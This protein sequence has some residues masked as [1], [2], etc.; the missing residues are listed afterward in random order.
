MAILDWRCAA[1]GATGAAVRVGGDPKTEEYRV[2]LSHDAQW[3]RRCH[4]PLLTWRRRPDGAKQ[5]RG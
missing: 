3:R 2:R 1:C 4:V 5:E